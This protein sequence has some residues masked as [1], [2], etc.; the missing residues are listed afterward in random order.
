MYMYMRRVNEN[1]YL[2][3]VNGLKDGKTAEMPNIPTENRL[4]V[5]F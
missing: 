4:Y 5:Y 2:I 1:R 3:N